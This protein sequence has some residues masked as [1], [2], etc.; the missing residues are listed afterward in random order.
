MG[1][2]MRATN[3]KVR[4]EKTSTDE[5][6]P[7]IQAIHD[8]GLNTDSHPVLWFDLFMPRER[9]RQ[10]HQ[11]VVTL[12][13]FTTWTNMKATMQNAGEGGV[14]YPE[15]KK[16]I[17]IELQQHLGLYILNGLCPSPQVSLKFQHPSENPVNGSQ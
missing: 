17:M 3:G 13:D 8:A 2:I 4:Y 15:F 12:A 9:K 10:E 1:R 6:G 14:V 7:N 11:D 16:F 5:T